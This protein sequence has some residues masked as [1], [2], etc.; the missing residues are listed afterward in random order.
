VGLKTLKYCPELD[1]LRTVAVA[2]VVLFHCAPSGPVSGGFIG[3]DLFFVLSAFLITTILREGVPLREFYIRRIRRL[4]PA[5][6]ALLAVYL[7]VAPLLWPGRNHP[8]EA[9]LAFYLA[10]YSYP[11]LGMP[12]VLRHTWSLAIE[13]QFYLI[14]PLLLPLI[15]KRPVL[16]LG[17]GWVAMTLWR[18]SFD[19]WAIYYYR[20]DTHATG[21]ILGALL[22]FVRPQVRPGIAFAAMAVVLALCF[23]GNIEQAN[24]SIPLAEIA[25]AALIAAA[26][27]GWGS[28][29]RHPVMVWGGKLSYG[30]Y[31]W[32]FPI[33]L[34]LRDDWGF[35]ATAAVTVPASIALAALSYFLVERRFLRKRV[36]GRGRL[37]AI[38]LGLDP[39]GR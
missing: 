36:E 7:L 17:I 16:I 37:P 12:H 3:V 4:W 13:E 23:V 9:F 32:H 25:S 6:L 24:A 39:V 30:I 2:A 8:F 15:A 26:V 31:L 38:E 34:Y 29:L 14:W 19:D 35:L 20:F 27:N 18:L 33:A 21:L 22:A 10:D 1:G 5:L 28:A 11:Y